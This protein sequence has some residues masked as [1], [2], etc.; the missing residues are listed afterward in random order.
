MYIYIHIY[1]H[2]YIYTYICICMCVHIYA[3]IYICLYLHG[4]RKD[5]SICTYILQ[6]HMCIHVAWGFCVAERARKRVQRVF[7]Y[8]YIWYD[9]VTDVSHMT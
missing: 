3:H 6:Q 9:F 2:I 4:F 7:V 8:K 5:I 1:I